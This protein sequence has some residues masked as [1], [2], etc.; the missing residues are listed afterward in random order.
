MMAKSLSSGIQLTSPIS[1]IFLFVS[2]I[3][4]SIIDAFHYEVAEE[5]EQE[6]E[7]NAAAIQLREAVTKS[8][9]PKLQQ[10][11]NGKV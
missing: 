4:C 1:N 5:G 2:R 7:S 8:I 9:M 10:C 3:L 6:N 11:I